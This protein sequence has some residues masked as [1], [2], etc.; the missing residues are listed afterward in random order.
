MN[1]EEVKSFYKKDGVVLHYAVAVDQVGLWKSEEILFT[2]LFLP[3]QRILEVG[4]G[5]GRIAFSL[6]RL[7]YHNITAID[8]SIDM[9]RVARAIAEEKAVTMDIRVGDATELE[10]EDNSFEGVIFGF[11]GLMQI[12][13]SDRRL[14]AMEEIFRVMKPG[15]MFFFT[16]HDREN[17]KNRKHW[18]KEIKCWRKGQQREEY[19]D[20]GDTIGDTDWGEMYIHVP[21]K[22]E[23]EAMLEAT[24]FQLL[25][26]KTRSFIAN[27]SQKTRAFSDECLLWVVKKPIN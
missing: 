22:G 16:T 6:H 4:C 8:Y 12:P 18:K 7:G 1:P 26:C 10:F 15:T 5:A 3:D 17:P 19:E 24:G 11:N 13:S 27:E 2:R 20:L 25:S 21:C 9:I 14:L 23:I